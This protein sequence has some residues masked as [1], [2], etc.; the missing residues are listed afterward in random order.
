MIIDELKLLEGRFQGLKDT[1]TVV[2]M[3]HVYAAEIGDLVGSVSLVDSP[4]LVMD[5]NFSPDW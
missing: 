4:A 5:P 1:K 3:E 2:N